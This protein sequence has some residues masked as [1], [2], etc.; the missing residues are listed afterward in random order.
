MKK[1]SINKLN[2][3]KELEETPKEGLKQ[4]FKSFKEAIKDWLYEKG[5]LCACCEVEESKESLSELFK[6]SDKAKET[7]IQEQNIS[8]RESNQKVA[9]DKEEDENSDPVSYII[10]EP[11]ES[12]LGK[13]KLP[14]NVFG[15]IRTT[16]SGPSS[17]SSS[18]ISD[19]S[20]PS[21]LKSTAIDTPPGLV[22]SF[23][24]TP[25][26][27]EVTNSSVM[28]SEESGSDKAI[29]DKVKL[30]EK[31]VSSS[32]ATSSDEP[33]VSSSTISDPSS[34]SS[35]KTTAIDTP[36][37]IGSSVSLTPLAPALEITSSSVVSS[38]ES[39]SDKVTSLQDIFIPISN[40]TKEVGV[41]GN[42]S[43]KEFIKQLPP[44]GRSL[45]D[46]DEAGFY[47]FD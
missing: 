46:V 10:I 12:D 26:T 19:P 20:S 33:G 28:S 21:S 27:P 6:A 17:V 9:K 44:V 2:L 8:K 42:V 40:N 41:I 30:S 13:V 14:Q 25:L 16:G 45:F 31:V 4:I 15:S 7:R 34:P 32:S 36:S 38:E 35:L 3:E 39:R 37:G 1:K 47:I 5:M 24:L 29:G 43:N 11:E 18:T 22:S 23:S